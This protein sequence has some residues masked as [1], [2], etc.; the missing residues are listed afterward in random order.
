MRVDH[1]DIAPAW[2][3]VGLATAWTLVES[4]GLQDV[5][6]AEPDSL[7]YL[8]HGGLVLGKVGPGQDGVQVGA[9]HTERGSTTFYRE[10]KERH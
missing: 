7:S 8:R 2:Y 3:L 1:S 9:L 4:R 5:P 10:T 6:P